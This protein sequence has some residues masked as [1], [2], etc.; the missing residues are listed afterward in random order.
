MPNHLQ[1]MPP[2]PGPRVWQAGAFLALLPSLVEGLV[3]EFAALLKAAPPQVTENALQALSDATTAAEGTTTTEVGVFGLLVPAALLLGNGAL[4]DA[5]R[6]AGDVAA[7]LIAGNHTALQQHG[8]ILDREI[9]A[10][11]DAAPAIEEGGARVSNAQ[12]E[13]R[14]GLVAHNSTAHREGMGWR[15]PVVAQLFR[16]NEGR[17]LMRLAVCRNLLFQRLYGITEFSE[18]ASR[19]YEERV[20]LIFRNF[21]L[22]AEHRDRDIE[23]RLV[24][25]GA[26]G[27]DASPWRL[28]AATDRDGRVESSL[29]FSDKEVALAGGS[30][31]HVRLEVRLAMPPE[32]EQEPP[33]TSRAVAY[34][35]EET[36]LSVISDIDDTVKV[37]EVFRG[38]GEI[39]KNTFLKEFRPVEGMVALYRR[40]AQERGANFQYV[41]KSP[42]EL[43]DPLSAFLGR[44][45]FPESSVHLCPIFSR[46]RS[47]FKE[48]RIEEL[49]QEFPKRRFVLVGDSGER[50]PEVFAELLRRHPAQI[51]KVLIRKVSPQHGVDPAVFEGCEPRQWQVFEEPS[52]VTL[53][54]PEPPAIALPGLPLPGLPGFPGLPGLP[55]SFGLPEVPGLLVGAT[56]VQPAVMPLDVVAE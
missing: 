34:L 2:W 24:S 50:D 15:V 44:E 29:W 28:L 1:E 11:V 37:T 30:G 56:A 49:L 12:A 31:G 19:L 51:E 13:P 46:D 26:P 55:G 3:P 21:E 5:V 52:E 36:G 42:P 45:G 7:S 14:L 54:V 53:E 47:S 17:H 9:Q 22:Y 38:H 10:A 20:R 41:S 39:L 4:A 33:P 25:D 43:H 35:V 23:A 16:R 6:Q 40:W 18:E 32:E 27:D 8:A 48:R